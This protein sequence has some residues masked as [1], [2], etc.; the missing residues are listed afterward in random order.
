[1]GDASNRA[2]ST[3][4]LRTTVS[5][6]QQSRAM[7]QI[8]RAK[9]VHIKPSCKPVAASGDPSSMEPWLLGAA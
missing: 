8:S 2:S 6:R 3:Y 5:R 1:M 4:F 7:P 9:P